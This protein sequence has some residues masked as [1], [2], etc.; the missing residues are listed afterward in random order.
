MPLHRRVPKRGLPQPVSSR[1]RVVISTRW[2]QVRAGTVVTP[3]LFSRAGPGGRWNRPVKVLARGEIDK[4]LT[5][6]VHK[7]SAK[8][9]KRSRPP[10]GQTETSRCGHDVMW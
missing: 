7:F 8:R 10:G 2:R 5:I 9:G 1:V 6:R 4:A 3:E